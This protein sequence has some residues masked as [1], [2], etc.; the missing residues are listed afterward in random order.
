MGRP[1]VGGVEAGD[2]TVAGEVV[3]LVLGVDPGAAAGVGT[4]AGGEVIA[5]AGVDEPGEELG[6]WA[7]SVVGGR[8]EPELDGSL[9][10]VVLTVEAEGE[11]A[12]VAVV[13]SDDGSPGSAKAAPALVVMSLADAGLMSSSSTT[14]TPAQ[15]TATAVALPTS[16]R[17]KKPR[18]LSMESL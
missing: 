1:A 10:T 2:G 8:T 11:S 13:R 7:P 6:D 9:S 5:G 17:A 16:Q 3:G 12:D 15:A 14:D 18:V 4:V